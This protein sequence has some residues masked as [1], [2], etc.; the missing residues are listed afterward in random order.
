MKT[1][2]FAKRCG[3]GGMLLLLLFLSMTARGDQEGDFEYSTGGTQA[4]ITGYLGPGGDVVIPDDLPGD[5]FD[6]LIR[7]PVTGIGRTFLGVTSLTSVTIPNSVTSIGGGSSYFSDP[8][9]TNHPNRFYR[10]RS[11]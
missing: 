10:L 3:L 1:L 9:W 2:R 11:P 8:Q 5:P 6:V 7:V 4:V